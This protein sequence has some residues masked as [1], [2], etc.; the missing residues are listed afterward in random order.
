MND[1]FKVMRNMRMIILIAIAYILAV[2]FAFAFC[3]EI[4]S[5]IYH[6]KLY[7]VIVPLLIL[8]VIA[9]KYVTKQ[10]KIY[11]FDQSKIFKI[12]RVLNIVLHSL[13]ISFASYSR[14][15]GEWMGTI[16]VLMPITICILIE[17]IA[18][19]HELKNTAIAE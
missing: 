10:S 8:D 16:T 2:G 5:S 4:L 9:S 11:E 3:E 6:I 15:H 13:W 17:S 14:T 19:L 18:L 7:V 12:N 1:N